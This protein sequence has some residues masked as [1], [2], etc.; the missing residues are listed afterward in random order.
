MSWLSVVSTVLLIG[1]WVA[2]RPAYYWLL[3]DDHPV[4]WAQFALLLAE[5]L[6]AVLAA[7]RFGR[8]GRLGPAAALAAVALASLLLAGEEISWGQRVVGWSTPAEFAA[9]NQQQET[10]LHNLEQGLPV[11]IIDLSK[12]VELLLALGGLALGLLARPVRSPF[13]RTALW[14]LAPP[15]FTLPALLAM[16]LYQGATLSVKRLNVSVTT[17]FQEWMELGFYLALA[18][19]V[20]CIYARAA[21][22]RVVVERTS[23][24]RLVRRLDAG[25]RVGTAPLLAV[26]GSVLALTVVFAVLTSFTGMLPGNVPDPDPQPGQ[27]VSR[28]SAA[29]GIGTHAGRFSVS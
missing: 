27:A 10:T 26:A 2:A 8:Q 3:R 9:K 28:S 21:K 19:S 14:Q 4:E 11:K 1:V 22:G 18:V 5:S 24:G 20:G 15:L 6:V 7:V 12:V 25:A 16:V 17:V 23:R 29:S 13:H